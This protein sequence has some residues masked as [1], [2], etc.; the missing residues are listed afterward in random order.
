MIVFYNQISKSKP[1]YNQFIKRI[2]KLI[3]KQQPQLVFLLAKEWQKQQNYFTY[4]DIRQGLLDGSLTNSMIRAWQDSYTQFISTHLA[5]IWEQAMNDAAKQITNKY[6][7]FSFNLTTANIR[8][9]T[10]NHAG[11]LIVQLTD[12]QTKGINSLIQMAATTGMSVD[13]LAKCIRPTVGL[14]SGQMTANFNYYQ[15]VKNNLLKNNPHMT[16]STATKIAS[17]KALKYA[18]KQH[19]YRAMNIARTELA[20]A[21]NR[22]EFESAKQAVQQGYMG[23]TVKRVITAGDNRVCSICRSLEGEEIELEAE[24]SIKNKSDGLTPPFHPSCRCCLEYFEV[25]PHNKIIA[26]NNIVDE[27]PQ[28]I[29][30]TFLEV[31]E[32]N[33]YAPVITD[34]IQ[35][36]NFL[37]HLIENYNYLLP[38]IKT[39]IQ[40]DLN[41]IPQSHRDI[42]LSEVKKVIVNKDGGSFYHPIYKIV[43]IKKDFDNFELIHEL[44]HAIET[45][46]NLFNNANFLRVLYN[47]MDD[48]NLLDIID[49]GNFWKPVN[50]VLEEVHIQRLNLDLSASKFLSEY[51]QRLYDYDYYGNYV[52]D[53]EKNEINWRC[54]IEY[55]SEGYREYFENPEN[56]KTKDI[57]LYNFIK[58]L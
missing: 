42:L 6:T 31:Y 10:T 49:E 44:G 58:E 52:V 13:E 2:R 12:T 7:S 32:D 4:K 46:L 57:Q 40:H 15:S 43:S 19:M 3:D 38:D 33:N 54:L 24:Y 51:Q 56:L 5:P 55:F 53:Y 41:L 48:V 30:Q 14:Y 17:E 20:F 1:N 34:D 27:P 47:E 29:A 11:E 35:T 18:E 22:G 21:Y 16:Q 25:E 23:H 28:S 45:Q 9:W 37:T 39:R 50:G 36:P 8:N 26:N